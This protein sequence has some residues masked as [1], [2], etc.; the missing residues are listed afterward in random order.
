MLEL[1]DGH[2]YQQQTPQDTTPPIA[3]DDVVT[4]DDENQP[5]GLL[6]LGRVDD[7][8]RGTD[9]EIRAAVV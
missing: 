2:C 5:R 6:G 9:V 4:I 3:N 8:M 7:L 1:T